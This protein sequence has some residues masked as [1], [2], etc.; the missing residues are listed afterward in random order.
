MHIK[1]SL[2]LAALLMTLLL[3]V[4]AIQHRFIIVDESRAQLHYVDQFKPSND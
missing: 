2:I 1:K 3:K 4:E